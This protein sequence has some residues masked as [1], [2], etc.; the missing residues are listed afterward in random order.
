MQLETRPAMLCFVKMCSL[1]RQTQWW[2]CKAGAAEWLI[3]VIISG[4]CSVVTVCLVIAPYSV[5]MAEMRLL[6]GSCPIPVL[7]S[8]S[9]ATSSYFVGDLQFPVNNAIITCFRWQ[10]ESKRLPY[11]AASFLLVFFFFFNALT[12]AT[13]S[14]ENKC[15][16]CFLSK[17]KRANFERI[18]N[19]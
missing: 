16:F 12:L 8:L 14:L 11:N 4:G 15:L 13:C 17:C 1:A 19:F 9:C 6:P 18:E 7:H 5:G 10:L 3:S 2:E